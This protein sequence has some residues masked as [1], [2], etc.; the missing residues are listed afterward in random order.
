MKIEIEIA[1][2]TTGNDFE[3]LL[4][5]LHSFCMREEIRPFIRDIV[6]NPNINEVIIE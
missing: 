2:D 4:V 3:E 6:I 5:K 1:R